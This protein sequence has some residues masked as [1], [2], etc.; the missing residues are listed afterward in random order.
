MECDD[1][2]DEKG[3]PKPKVT[4]KGFPKS[5]RTKENLLKLQAGETLSYER[6]EKIRTLARGGFHYG[7]QMTTV[8]KSFKTPYSK[9]TVFDDGTTA[10]FVF[11]EPY[12]FVEVTTEEPVSGIRE[13]AQAFDVDAATG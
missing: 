9:R 4:M 13:R 12:S 10:P 7:P 1:W 6:L 5:L 2:V 11:S 8:K 3:N